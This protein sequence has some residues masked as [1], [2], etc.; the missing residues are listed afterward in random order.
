[1]RKQKKSSKILSLYASS[2]KSCR[3][4][5]TKFIEMEPRK[6]KEEIWLGV[7]GQSLILYAKAGKEMFDRKVWL[8]HKVLLGREHLFHLCKVRADG[9]E[10]EEEREG[11]F[12]YK[13]QRTLR[14]NES[15]EETVSNKIT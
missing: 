12:F 14:K 8:L 3:D 11:N 5:V 6:R 9:N 4:S 1:M 7:V 15:V 13:T 10:E 2:T